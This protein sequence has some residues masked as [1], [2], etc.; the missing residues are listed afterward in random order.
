LNEGDKVVS[1]VVSN[2]SGGEGA[3]SPFGSPFGRRR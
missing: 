1:G 2:G 3:N